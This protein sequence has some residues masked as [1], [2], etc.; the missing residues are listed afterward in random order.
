M[1]AASRAAA[2]WTLGTVTSILGNPRYT[3]RQVWNRQRTDSELADPAN[4]SLGHKSV[5][6]WNLPDW[7]VISDRPAHP[8]LVSEADF[9]AAQDISAA[10]GPASVIAPAA[11][12]TRR[13]LLAGLLACGT[14]GRRMESAWS[15]PRGECIQIPMLAVWCFRS[16]GPVVSAGADRWIRWTT[17]GCVALLALIAGTVSYLHM[18]VL[19][20]LHGQPGW[21]AA[22]TPLSVDGMIV[23]ASTTL[24]ADSR[25]GERGGVLP[26]ALL[27]VG[28]AAS[29]AANVTVAQ[30]TVA[31]R[32]IAAWPSFALIGAYELLMRQVRR[33][34]AGTTKPQPRKFGPQSS[35]AGTGDGG[36]QRSEG[37]RPSRGGPEQGPAGAGSK[38]KDLQ[39]QAWHWALAHRA[40]DGSLPSGREVADQ[41]G[42]HERWGRL[43]K[44]AGAAGAFSAPPSEPAL[45]LVG[46]Q[47][48][49][50][51]CE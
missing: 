22:L 9:I 10:R 15:C 42:R 6:R 24:L 27:V 46:Q 20:E 30:P 7:W 40:F 18:H 3:G 29:L 21:V 26:W 11:P 16:W 35:H 13:Y 39:Q 47:P 37:R 12:G 14:C 19:V 45:H 33:S 25:A 43:V 2:A 34:A 32:V 23:A 49:P 8:A 17:T 44:R 41:H 36:V 5:Q 4:T 48:T 51:A 28:S 38:G 50:A 31:G 1:P